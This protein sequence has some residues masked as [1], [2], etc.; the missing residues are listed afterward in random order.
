MNLTFVCEKIMNF[1]IMLYFLQIAK[2]TCNSEGPFLDSYTH[3][4]TWGS[5]I[6]HLGAGDYY[7]YHYYYYSY[8]C[9][10][11]YYCYYG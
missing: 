11:Y 8:Y 7:Y 3:A 4:C 2:R 1:L 9:Y 10:Y 6:P 5:L